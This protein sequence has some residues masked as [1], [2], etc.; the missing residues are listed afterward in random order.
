MR[1]WVTRDEPSDGP[2][3]SALKQAQLQVL[4]EPVLQRNILTDARSEIAQL[5]L[6][7]WLVLTS[8]FAINTVAVDV[9]RVPKVAV[10]GQSSRD[11]ALSRGFHVELVSSD[12]TANSLF[13][14]LFNISA[15]STICYPRSSL[16]VSPD[17]PDNITMTSPVLY[18]T[19]RREYRKDILNEADV[20]AVTSASAVYAVGPIDMRFASIGVSTSSALREIGI[21]P[22]VEAA[23]PNFNALAR[24]IADQR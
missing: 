22:W 2:L 15:G 9:A 3:C 7:D 11:T 21:E 4:H 17:A 8:T 18:E 10:V 20:A 1:V 12:G 13:D 24:A 23:E 16:A 14:E 6:D 19:H 5:T